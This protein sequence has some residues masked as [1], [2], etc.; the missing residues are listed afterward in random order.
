VL[1]RFPRIFDAGRPPESSTD[2]ERAPCDATSCVEAL[3]RELAK[4]TAKK[5]SAAMRQAET[6]VKVI[7]SALQVSPVTQLPWTYRPII[8]PQ[9]KPLETR[10]CHVLAAI[11]DWWTKRELERRIESGGILQSDAAARKV[12]SALAQIHPTAVQELKNTYRVELPSVVTRR[13]EQQA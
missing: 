5:V 10:D 8:L 3:R 13:S 12:S 4:G 9:A 1:V 2:R 7:V 11:R 6:Q